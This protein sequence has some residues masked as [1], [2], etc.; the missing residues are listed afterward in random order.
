MARISNQLRI[1]PKLTARDLRLSSDSEID[2]EFTPPNATRTTAKLAKVSYAE[3]QYE[4][5]LENTKGCDE[6]WKEDKSDGDKARGGKTKADKVQ[7]NKSTSKGDKTVSKSETADKKKKIAKK[8]AKAGGAG[9]G[10]NVG[11]KEKKLKDE[12]LKKNNK[13]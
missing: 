8:G 5:M 4:N 2:I 3:T 11:K 12:K 1:K 13:R 6:G 10:V 9:D 7:R